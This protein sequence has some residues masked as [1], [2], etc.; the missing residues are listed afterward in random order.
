MSTE[1]PTLQQMAVALRDALQQIENQRNETA[2]LREQLSIQQTIAE[3]AVAPQPPQPLTDAETRRELL[4]QRK[5][6]AATFRQNM[7]TYGGE[8][9]AA[10]IDAFLE[11]FEN[12]STAAGLSMENAMLVFGT[13]LTGKA[14]EWWEFYD[15]KERPLIAAAEQW[16]G[17]KAALAKEFQ[18]IQHLASLQAALHSLDTRNGLMDYIIKMRKIIRQLGTLA[19]EKEIWNVL[20][21]RIPPSAEMHLRALKITT[22][23]KALEELQVYAASYHEKGKDGRVSK[24]DKSNKPRFDKGNRHY[25]ARNSSSHSHS[26]DPGHPNYMDVDAVKLRDNRGSSQDYRQQR[27]D[28]SKFAHIV[29][30]MANY[31]NFD[32]IPS[33]TDNLRKF[34]ADNKGCFYCRTLNATHGSRNCPKKQNRVSKN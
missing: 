17:V 1:E 3:S 14:R 4:E 22:T 24:G 32:V 11:T 27:R 28:T 25:T 23:A 10:K 13:F 5:I 30:T 18:P 31:N 26:I 12:Y 6:M 33:M 15:K 8:K 29:P 16:K 9:D 2:Q 7:R 34:L 21:Y 19:S 20:M